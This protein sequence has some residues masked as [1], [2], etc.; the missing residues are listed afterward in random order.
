MH[1]QHSCPECDQLSTS[2]GGIL[3]DWTQIPEMLVVNLS[4]RDAWLFHKWECFNKSKMFRTDQRLLCLQEYFNVS[5]ALHWKS[6][7]AFTQWN[8][9]AAAADDDDNNVRKCPPIK[10]ENVR[11][12]I[13]S[14]RHDRLVKQLPESSA[15]APWVI[16][17]ALGKKGLDH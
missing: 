3:K 6:T 7:L 5:A 17:L 2:T 1:L 15:H 11:R 4:T 12:S 9:A 14:Q 8:A 13:D 10:K 16:S